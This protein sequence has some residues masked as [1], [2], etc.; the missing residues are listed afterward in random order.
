VSKTHLL[1][2]PVADGVEVI[3]RNSSNGTHLTHR[4]VRRS[5]VPGEPALAVPDDIIH[6]GQRAALVRRA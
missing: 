6:I 2:R 3:D 5:L 4:G 1:V